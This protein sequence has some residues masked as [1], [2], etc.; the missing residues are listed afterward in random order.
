MSSDHPNP[1]QLDTPF[2]PQPTDCTLDQIHHV[3]F[4]QHYSDLDSR[5]YP[6]AVLLYYPDTTLQDNS[7]NGYKW[8]TNNATLTY[9][10]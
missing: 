3:P 9:M 8:T 10:R 5:T 1:Y 4:L 2:V 7:I 6:N